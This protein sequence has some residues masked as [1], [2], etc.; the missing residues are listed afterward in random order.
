MKVMV[1]I[2][3]MWSILMSEEVIMPR[4]MTTLT[5]CE[6]SL[7]RDRHT[8][9]QTHTWL[10]QYPK[11]HNQK[12]D[13]TGCLKV[14]VEHLSLFRILTSLSLCL[15]LSISAKRHGHVFLLSFTSLCQSQDGDARRPG[16]W[17]MSS[18]GDLIP[19]RKWSNLMFESRKTLTHTHTHNLINWVL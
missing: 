5:V 14:P 10:H 18:A 3:N 17:W 4:L 1:N 6:E 2:I 8:D 12:Q 16:E 7:A 19:V 15:S 9:R 13:G 11:P